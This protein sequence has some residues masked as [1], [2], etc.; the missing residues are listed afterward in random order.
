MKCLRGINEWKYSIIAVILIVSLLIILMHYYP[1]NPEL[2]I[3]I[4]GV[5]ISAFVILFGV[6]VP[7]VSMSITS[8][9]EK[10]YSFSFHV[11]NVSRF[12]VKFYVDVNLKVNGELFDRKNYPLYGG[13]ESWSLFPNQGIRGWLDIDGKLIKNKYDLNK[14]NKLTMEIKIRNAGFSQLV[15]RYPITNWHFNFKEKVWYNTDYWYPAL[16]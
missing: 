1:D 8:I 12:P 16:P 9:K 10:G 5:L 15:I 13:M 3:G 14:I 6:A 4:S 7:T 11:Q 2:S